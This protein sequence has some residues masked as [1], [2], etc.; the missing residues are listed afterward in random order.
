MPNATSPF[1][2]HRIVA[3]AL[4]HPGFGPARVSTELRRDKWGGIVISPS[5]VWRMLKRHGLNTRGK[6]L[7]LVAGYA[8]PPQ[9]EK[10]PV[11]PKQHLQVEAPDEYW[12]KWTVSMWDACEACRGRCGRIT[13]IDVASS[14][15]WAQLWTTPRNATALR[16]SQLARRVAHDLST[17]GW[18]LQAVMTDN[19]SEY[20]SKVFRNTIEEL[21]AQH[22]FIR[23]GRPQTNGCVERVH[24]TI[25]EE[26]WKPSFAH[27]LTPKITGLRLDL[28]HYLDY[29]NTDR[30]HTGRWNQGRTR[31]TSPRE[32]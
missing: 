26:C 3:F 6:R 20:P 23:A 24:L 19:G 16:T 25:L 13:A 12:Y 21:D 4:G 27:Y 1:V 28:N 10:P 9:P 17:R 29:Y 30:A 14:Y 31:R 7:G 11:L 8:A 2:E 22:R 18:K 5:G 32:T 15:T